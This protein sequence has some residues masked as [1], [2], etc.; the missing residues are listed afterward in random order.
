MEAPQFR[1]KSGSEADLDFTFNR[2]F[3]RVLAVFLTYMSCL[4]VRLQV[5]YYTTIDVET[6]RQPQYDSSGSTRS[7]IAELALGTRGRRKA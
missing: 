2:S 6:D 3:S 5:S 4:T 7:S 1:L